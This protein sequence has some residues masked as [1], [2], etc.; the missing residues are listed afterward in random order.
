MFCSKCG[1]EIKEG[2]R[3]C[4]K[5]GNPINS[6][7]TYGKA[8][9]THQGYQGENRQNPGTEMTRNKKPPYRAIGV[10][11]IAVIICVLFVKGIFFKNTYE[12]PLK[13]MVKAIESQDIQGVLSILPPKLLEVAEEKS[14]MDIDELLDSVGSG[15]LDEFTDERGDVHINYKITDV[16]DMTDEEIQ[17][18]EQYFQGY[19]GD[20]KEGKKLN[21]SYQVKM[22]E[23]E[24][25]EGEEGIEVIKIDGK[26]YINP[27]SVL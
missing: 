10:L 3:F 1:Q 25:D 22:D 8:G 27:G 12:T 5:C 17:D 23:H 24:E 18:I 9:G 7:E 4:P 13:N 19:L 16:T 15:V 11:L 21:F 26:W 20:I 2:A 6:G 14:G